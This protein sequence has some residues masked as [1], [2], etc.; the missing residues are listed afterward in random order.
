MITKSVFPYEFLARWSRVDGSLQGYHG[1]LATVILE[2]GVEIS[3]TESEAMGAA[4]LEAAGFT[5]DDLLGAVHLTA[6]AERDAA[7]AERNAALKAK[8]AAEAER[9]AA[10]A[11]KQQLEAVSDERL[12]INNS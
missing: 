11:E 9:D 4:A 6:L 7:L 2:D 1:K 12:S 8:A 3:R 5:L 10:I